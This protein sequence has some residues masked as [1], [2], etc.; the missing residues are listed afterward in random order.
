VCVWFHVVSPV[1]FYG[2]VGRGV[3]LLTHEER[4]WASSREISYPLLFFSLA[5]PAITLPLCTRFGGYYYYYVEILLLFDIEK[6]K[7]FQK[8][9]SENDVSF[10]VCWASLLSR[11]LGPEWRHRFNNPRR[12]EQ[13][14][15]YS[16][17][18]EEEARRRKTMSRRTTVGTGGS[19]TAV[20]IFLQEI[21]HEYY[22]VK[23]YR[24]Y[25]PKKGCC[26]R[27]NSIVVWRPI[28]VAG[29]SGRAKAVGFFRVDLSSRENF[30][31][32][33]RRRRNTFAGIVV[34]V[35]LFVSQ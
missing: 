33:R 30:H 24:V 35:Q 3:T 31:N 29:W 27:D 34:A 28:F 5:R 12:A 25:Y 6:R 11:H 21:V 19:F 17:E 13:P 14:A 2:R 16:R 26:N 4:A 7:K 15:N 10:L 1:A 18:I 22:N 23:I 9:L 20:W 32:K 8:S